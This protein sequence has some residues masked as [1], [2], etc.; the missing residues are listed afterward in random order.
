[1]SHS[2]ILATVV[3]LASVACA[4][5]APD[6]FA[7]GHG[8]ARG[9]VAR[10]SWD[11]AVAEWCDRAGLCAETR[12]GGDSAVLVGDP[13]KYLD[14]AVGYCYHRGDG[15]SEIGALARLEGDP[16]RMRQVYLHELGHHFGCRHSSS[17]A[18]VMYPDSVYWQATG[19]LTNDDVACV[20]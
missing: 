11:A 20:D 2:L 4:P 17:T 16:D 9:T 8:M 18:D 3:A 15:T 12:A 19:H 5:D 6:V 7:P 13:T 14:S 10:A 1:M